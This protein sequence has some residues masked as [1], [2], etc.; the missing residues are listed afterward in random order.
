MDRCFCLT[1][2]KST[3]VV[4]EASIER[5]LNL[6]LPFFLDIRHTIESFGR[7][8]I[9]WHLHIQSLIESSSFQN[10]ACTNPKNIHKF[11]VGL[12][13][14][15]F[16]AF[17]STKRGYFRYTLLSNISVEKVLLLV[18]TVI[19]RIFSTFEIFYVKS[20]TGKVQLLFLSKS[21][22]VRCEKWRKLRKVQLASKP[23][24]SLIL[25]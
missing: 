19:F 10:P 7:K 6:P 16:F 14:L 3:L 5:L 2:H 15:H 8:K 22:A 11:P 25:Q 17:E 9:D 18:V 20:L 4:N 13:L 1:V 21:C 12:F 23:L 24:C